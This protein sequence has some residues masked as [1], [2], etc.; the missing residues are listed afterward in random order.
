MLRHAGRGAQ[1]T[2]CK[3][4]SC[5]NYT[6]ASLILTTV[7]K[8]RYHSAYPASDEVGTSSDTTQDSR[9]S[10]CHRLTIEWSFLL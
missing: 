10:R 9:T 3:I 6:Q 7:E 1:K 5:V 8:L 2:I 4:E